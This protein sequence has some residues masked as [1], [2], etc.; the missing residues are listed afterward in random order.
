MGFGR[1][2]CHI[3]PASE[4]TLHLLEPHLT[5]AHDQTPPAAEPQAGDVERRLE[6]ALHAR[7]V[8]DPLAEL[9]HAFLAA[10]GLGRHRT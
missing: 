6:H 3:G 1:D 10:V 2:Q 7:L 5:T 4:Q 8:A 9:T